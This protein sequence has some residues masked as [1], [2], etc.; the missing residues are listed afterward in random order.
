MNLL[1]VVVVFVIKALG[2][3]ATNTKDDKLSSVDDT[4]N[5]I[6]D[7]TAFTTLDMINVL[8]SLIPMLFSPFA[9]LWFYRED[10]NLMIQLTRLRDSDTLFKLKNISQS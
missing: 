5:V 2:L 8:L 4:L 3:S 6:H 9:Y 7:G 1:Q 10:K